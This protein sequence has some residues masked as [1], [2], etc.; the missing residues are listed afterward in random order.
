MEEENLHKGNEVI[1]VQVLDVNRHHNY[2]NNEQILIHGFAR[3]E[4]HFLHIQFDQSCLHDEHILLLLAGD[5]PELPI[6]PEIQREGEKEAKLTKT[7]A[8]GKRLH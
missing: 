5:L 2:V 7:N 1:E 6:E 4:W 8:V 3:T